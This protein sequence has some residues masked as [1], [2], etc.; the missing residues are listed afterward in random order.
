MRKIKE[1]LRLRF[2]LGL[3]QDQIARSCNIAQPTVHRYLERAAA[4]GV[5]WPLPAGCD[6]RQL[7]KLLFPTTPGWEAGAVRPM[8]DWAAIHEQLQG[9]AAEQAR[10]CRTG[11]IATCGLL[12][13]SRGLRSW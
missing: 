4:A 3:T 10:H 1:V 11:L 6:E 2:D 8:P 9:R 7:E 13:F 12:S 5:G